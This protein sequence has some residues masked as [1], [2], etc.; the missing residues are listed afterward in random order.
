VLQKL[1]TARCKPRALL[2]DKGGGISFSLGVKIFPIAICL[3]SSEL[4][5]TIRANE[6]KAGKQTS[7]TEV[8]NAA[9][10]SK[11]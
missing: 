6:L 2:L 3:L 5:A 8:T 10:A 9:E 11:L 7:P 4:C 1:I